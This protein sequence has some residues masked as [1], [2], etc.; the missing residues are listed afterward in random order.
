MQDDDSLTAVGKALILVG[1]Y[2]NNGTLMYVGSSQMVRT[3]AVKQ[4]GTSWQLILLHKGLNVTQQ[5]ITLSSC[6]SAGAVSTV[7]QLTGTDYTDPK[8]TLR[9]LPNISATIA[10]GV[11]SIALPPVSITAIEF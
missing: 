5:D 3:W 6:L 7:W 1:K 8:P 9:Q 10:N 4:L 11:L 2:L